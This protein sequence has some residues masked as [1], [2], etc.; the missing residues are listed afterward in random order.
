MK[1][2]TV[3]LDDVVPFKIKKEGVKYLKLKKS[4]TFSENKINCMVYELIPLFYEFCLQNPDVEPLH[5]FEYV[6]VE[7]TL[8]NFGKE[9]LKGKE[10]SF[11][12]KKNGDKEIIRCSFNELS[13]IFGKYYEGNYYSIYNPFLYNEIKLYINK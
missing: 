12:I 3:Y 6:E 5:N 9:F 1:E 11:K 10:N 8:S 13:R 2:V 7:V 4:K